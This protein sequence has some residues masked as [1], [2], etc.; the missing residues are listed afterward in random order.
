MHPVIVVLIIAVS[1]WSIITTFRAIYFIHRKP[2]NESKIFWTIIVMVGV[3]GPLIWLFKRR[4][5]NK[6][7]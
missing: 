4:K 5:L 6:N 3:I 7:D 2:F 1:F